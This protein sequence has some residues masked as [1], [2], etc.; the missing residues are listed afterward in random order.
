MESRGHMCGVMHYNS[1]VVK[2][3]FSPN[4]LVHASIICKHLSH[5]T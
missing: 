3:P 5:F 2:L 4:S 1:I